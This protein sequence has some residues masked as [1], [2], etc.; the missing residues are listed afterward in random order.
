MSPPAS[1]AARDG[2]LVAA[3]VESQ[4]VGMLGVRPI[5]DVIEHAGAFVLALANVTGTVVD[6]GT[7]GGVPGLVIARARPD[8]RLVLVDRRSSRTDHLQR[9]VARLGLTDRVE[10]LTVDAI[11]LGERRAGVADAVV[12]RGFGAP[13]STLRA[14]APL[15]RSGGLIVV[16]EPPRH[17]LDRWPQA[18]LDELGLVA[19]APAD[20]RVAVFRRPGATQTE[21]GPP[22][23]AGRP[24]P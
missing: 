13:A 22:S 1:E 3:L 2:E 15:V 7:G 14:A 23:V 17:A 6:L 4:R 18:L 16:S 5:A 8:L 9:L 11:V 12:A 19:T 24:N 21:G 10:V 20:R